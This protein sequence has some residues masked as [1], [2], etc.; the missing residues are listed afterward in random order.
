[1]RARQAYPAA[2]L[3]IFIKVQTLTL[4][5]LLLSGVSLQQTTQEQEHLGQNGA[6]ASF[7]TSLPDS[8]H[9]PI[10]A[11]PYFDFI[12]DLGENIVPTSLKLK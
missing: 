11:G 6:P 8:Q 7:I 1:M 4:Q 12:F 9:L 3:E 5:Q 2:F 10:W